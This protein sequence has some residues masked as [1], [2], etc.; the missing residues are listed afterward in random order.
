MVVPGFFTSPPANVT[1][2]HASAENMQPDCET[3]IAAN[4]PKPVNALS[5]AVSG[6]TSRGVQKWEKFATTASCLKKMKPRRMRAA[7]ATTLA[8]VKTFCTILP[9]RTPRVLDQVSSP[10]TMIPASWLVESETA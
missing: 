1:L 5:E 7:S 8:D 2:F 9:Y 3:Q 4:R 6:V 10:I